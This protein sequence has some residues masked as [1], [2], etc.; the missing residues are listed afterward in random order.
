MPRR[1]AV[2]RPVPSQPGLAPLQSSLVRRVHPATG[3]WDSDRM[4]CALRWRAVI[5]HPRRKNKGAPRVGHPALV[6][7]Q[8]VRDRVASHLHIWSAESA[9]QGI[10]APACQPGLFQLTATP[11]KDRLTEL[12]RNVQI[13]RTPLCAR[14]C[15]MSAGM[16]ARPNDRSPNRS[17]AHARQAL[18]RSRSKHVPIARPNHAAESHVPIEMPAERVRP[19]PQPINL[20]FTEQ[21][22]ASP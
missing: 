8:A 13:E 5:S 15:N 20:P 17:D 21:Q 18:R 3:C 16:A 9:L 6:Q 19:G 10:K 12:P 22:G 11:G 4:I 7:N 14:S 1:L 2:P